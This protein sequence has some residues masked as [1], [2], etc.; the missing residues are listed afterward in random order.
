MTDHLPLKKYK[1]SNTTVC[2]VH[3]GVIYSILLIYVGM[4]VYLISWVYF[5]L[6]ASY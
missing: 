1:Q 4:A 3:I 6:Y 2:G 5:G